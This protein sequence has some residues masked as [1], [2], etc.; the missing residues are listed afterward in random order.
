MKKV[1]FALPIMALISCKAYKPVVSCPNYNRFE[2]NIC[3]GNGDVVVIDS[4]QTAIR[5]S[6]VLIKNDSTLT[7][8]NYVLA[9]GSFNR[10]L[11]KYNGKHILFECEGMI[12]NNFFP[13]EDI[14]PSMKGCV[15][16]V[17]KSLTCK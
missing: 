15:E 2:K 17:E 10:S 3:R 7:T 5:I 9:Y 6:G 8:Y 14:L 11:R 12:P 1:L 4:T 16:T 13:G